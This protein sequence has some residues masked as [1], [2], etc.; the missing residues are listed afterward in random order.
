MVFGTAFA[1]SVG[2]KYMKYS[3]IPSDIRASPFLPFW[4]GLQPGCE[5][6]TE[7]M[8]AGVDQGCIVVDPIAKFRLVK[9]LDRNVYLQMS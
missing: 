8:H 9:I 6:I 7:C 3:L 1:A 5:G 2:C 4:E